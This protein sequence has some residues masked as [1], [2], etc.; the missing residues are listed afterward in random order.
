MRRKAR[1]A[2]LAAL[3]ALALDMRMIRLRDADRALQC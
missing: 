1:L 3:A 2:A